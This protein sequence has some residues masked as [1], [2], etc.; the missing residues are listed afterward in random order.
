M[1]MR[2]ELVIIPE[3]KEMKLSCHLALEN[4]GVAKTTYN[5]L[6]MELLIK[7]ALTKSFL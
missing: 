3:T 1:T 6:Q 4:E 7:T 5:E 2:K